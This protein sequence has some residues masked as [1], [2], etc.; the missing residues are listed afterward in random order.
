MQLV[1]VDGAGPRFRAHAFDRVGIES[2]QTRSGF[3]V[4]PTAAH[5]RAGAT[6]FQRR[7]VEE[8]VRTRAQDLQRQR[9]RL[10]QV[11]VLDADL[12]G[13]DRAQQPLQSLDVHRLVQA[14]V[15]RLVHERM[16]G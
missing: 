4:E 6:L 16:V 9:R 15:N 7:V 13:F 12:A 8:R 14:I 2:A 10:R 3:F 11:A 5:D 1:R